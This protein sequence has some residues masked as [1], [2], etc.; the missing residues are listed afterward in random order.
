MI[1]FA[2]LTTTLFTQHLKLI[3]LTDILNFSF[4]SFELLFGNLFRFFFSSSLHC[5]ASSSVLSKRMNQRTKSSRFQRF[6]DNLIRSQYWSLMNYS[7]L[8]LPSISN[9]R[10]KNKFSFWRLE[11]SVDASKIR[12]DSFI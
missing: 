3:Y 7:Y 1:L 12:V 6:H 8:S 5:S 10:S 2:S 9:K 4:Y 11:H